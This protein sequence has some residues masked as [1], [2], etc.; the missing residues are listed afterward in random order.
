MD[1]HSLT[2]AQFHSSV[3]D[4]EAV[5]LPRS[6]FVPS[7]IVP[8]AFPVLTQVQ[9]QIL[10]VLPTVV[11]NVRRGHGWSG[12][13]VVQDQVPSTCGRP[14]DSE[15]EQWGNG[16]LLGQ[17][18]ISADGGCGGEGGDFSVIRFDPRVGPAGAEDTGQSGVVC[19]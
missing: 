10:D 2:A 6:A 17:L 12:G 15:D 16:Q 4:V 19:I 5:F 1:G 18:P 3:R 8:T 13:G 11:T 14:L 9:G 7:Q